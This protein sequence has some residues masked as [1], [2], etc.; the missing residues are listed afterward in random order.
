MTAGGTRRGYQEWPRHTGGGGG[1][2]C[3]PC[4]FLFFLSVTSS[5]GRGII[6]ARG[7]PL[8]SPRPRCPFPPGMPTMPAAA[9]RP[10]AAAARRRY[11]IARGGHP[12][13][14]P[15]HGRRRLPASR[16]SRPSSAGPAPTG[17]VPPPS[18]AHPP[19]PP[20]PC[21]HCCRGVALHG[22]LGVH[23]RRPF[24]P[25]PGRRG[26]FVDL[27]G[28]AQTPPQRGGL[29]WRLTRVSTGHATP[30]PVTPPFPPLFRSIPQKENCPSVRW[31]QPRRRRGRPGH[32]PP[33]RGH[34]PL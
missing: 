23:P 26:T 3:T 34:P 5:R 11:W 4:A 6:A 17:A 21:G 14:P 9:P 32:R 18:T 1:P 27:L 24:G 33:S 25:A 10:P 13:P 7:R 16:G 30:L 19:R 15:C 2:A 29:F 31:P 8:P 22:S 12:P 28:V 20:P